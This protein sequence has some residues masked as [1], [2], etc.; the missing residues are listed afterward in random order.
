[1]IVQCSLQQR[2][3]RSQG[4]QHL[5]QRCSLFEARK[6]RKL[7]RHEAHGA[8]LP[9]I[10]FP[11]NADLSLPQILGHETA[12]VVV[13]VG[14]NV[15]N[16]KPGDRVALEPGKSCRMCPDCKSGQYNR[17]PEMV[18]PFFFFSLFLAF[19]HFGL[20]LSRF[21]CRFSPPLLPSM[22]PSRVTTLSR[23]TCAT[24]FLRT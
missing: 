1:M 19:A 9:F 10:S 22:V 24:S 23:L 5:R 3:R 18:R 15:Q 12:A 13:K 20:T 6:D 14:S 16:V 8:L 7:R 2:H 17:C 11:Q 4:R 21:S